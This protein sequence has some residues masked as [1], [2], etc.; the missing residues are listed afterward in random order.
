MLSSTHVEKDR[1]D[2]TSL[3]WKARP[4]G[5]WEE[6]AEA[7][8]GKHRITLWLRIWAPDLAWAGIL[9]SAQI[10]SGICSLLMDFSL[11]FAL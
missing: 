8:D 6:W 3:P 2:F 11:P 5:L 1:R 7:S 10:S 4:A 9:T